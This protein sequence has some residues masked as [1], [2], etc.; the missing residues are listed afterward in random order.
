MK[1]KVEG[2]IEKRMRLD[3]I[4]IEELRWMECRERKGEQGE[5]EE[6][7][8]EGEG[9]RDRDENEAGDKG[10]K[11]QSFVWTIESLNK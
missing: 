8:G 4:K 5:G 7:E 6:S 11:T 10:L 9:E 3:V 1:L 2:G